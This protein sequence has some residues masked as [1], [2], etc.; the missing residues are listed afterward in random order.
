MNIHIQWYDSDR[1]TVL[2]VLS[3]GIEWGSFFAALEHVYAMAHTEGHP[4][5][6]IFDVCQIAYLPHDTDLH[7]REALRRCRGFVHQ[8]ITVGEK[9]SV[10]VLVKFARSTRSH[11]PGS[12]H[13]A[14]GWD[15]MTH[16]LPPDVCTQTKSLRLTA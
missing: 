7:L 4:V 16:L 11:R 3:D 12:V 13:M 6:I 2:M 5:N 15:A 8:I 10:D 1:S 9:R 14:H